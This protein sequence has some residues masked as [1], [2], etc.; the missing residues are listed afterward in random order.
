LVGYGVDLIELM[1]DEQD[2]DIP[3][4]GEAPDDH[5]KLV[6]LVLLKGRRGLVKKQVFRI[7]VDRSR[8]GSPIIPTTIFASAP[9]SLST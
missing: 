2:A 8:S 3:F 9:R 5:E 4:S 1:V 6:D 7:T